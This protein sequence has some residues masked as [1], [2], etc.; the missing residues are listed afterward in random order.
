M[1]TS[2]TKHLQAIYKEHLKTI[3]RANKGVLGAFF[4]NFLKNCC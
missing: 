1:S 3:N 4:D 2:K